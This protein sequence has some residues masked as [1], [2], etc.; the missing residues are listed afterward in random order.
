LHVAQPRES[1]R[2]HTHPIYLKLLEPTSNSVVGNEHKRSSRDDSRGLEDLLRPG[3]SQQFP[4]THADRPATFVRRTERSRLNDCRLCRLGIR[5][6]FLKKT[7]AFE[8]GIL[9]RSMVDQ[10]R[11][12][13]R[14]QCGRPVRFRDRP[15]IHGGTQRPWGVKVP[16]DGAINICS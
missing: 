12:T 3:T 7:R 11:S 9:D 4:A 6:V 14:H 1:Y 13:L 10:E 8:L 16:D 15:L 5:R 2:S